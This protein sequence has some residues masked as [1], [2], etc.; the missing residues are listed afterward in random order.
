M[1][2]WWVVKGVRDIG[3]VTPTFVTSFDDATK[4]A[5]LSWFTTYTAWPLEALL[6]ADGSDA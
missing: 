5:A 3:G 1:T 2:R 6:D 4:R